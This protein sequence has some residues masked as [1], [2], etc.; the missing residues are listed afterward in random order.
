MAS[1]LSVIDGDSGESLVIQGYALNT[2][3]VGTIP[4]GPTESLTALIAIYKINSLG[5]FGSLMPR[6]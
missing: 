6:I 5:V 2:R 3:S 4:S 1:A